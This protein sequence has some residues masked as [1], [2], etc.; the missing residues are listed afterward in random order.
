MEQDEMS[1]S[2]KTGQWLRK[3]GSQKPSNKWLYFEHMKGYLSDQELGSS[4]EQS[5]CLAKGTNG[6]MVMKDRLQSHQCIE[7][8]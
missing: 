6:I 4:T 3:N 5:Y 7:Q 2:Q 1:L 8:T